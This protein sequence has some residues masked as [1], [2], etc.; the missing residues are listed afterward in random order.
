M[1]VQGGE[2]DVCDSCWLVGNELQ[3]VDGDAGFR[4]V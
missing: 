2:D 4:R 1:D 3:D